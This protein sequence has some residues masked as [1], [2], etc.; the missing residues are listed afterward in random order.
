[1]NFYRIIRILIIGLIIIFSASCAGPIVRDSLGDID[2]ND[3]IDYS[4]Y[5]I[6]NP[7]FDDQAIY[8]DV[9]TPHEGSLWSTQ[10]RYGS[11]FSDTKARNVNDI[12]TVNIV[13]TT[14]VSSDASTQL[15]SSG[16]TESGI[17]S[18]F[19]SPMS[20][21]LDNLYGK[22]DPFDPSI[23]TEAEN[24]YNGSGSTARK[25]K[26]LTTLSARV[27]NVFP[28]GN[29]LIKGNREITVNREKQKI[30][31]VGLVR[32]E[33][34][35]AQNVVLS[36][37]IADAKISVTGKGVVSEEQNPGYG[38]RFYEWLWPFK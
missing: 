9:Q 32:P 29:M 15:S 30:F 5:G 28:N 21:G 3:T 7:D 22:D 23:A 26:F 1:M 16:S 27:I 18:F 11:L 31:L 34:V 8:I 19:G 24:K 36:T 17:T 37:A 6:K 33:D 12:L 2:N 20:F 38:S 14:D 13:E 25:H 4:S 10:S 35:S